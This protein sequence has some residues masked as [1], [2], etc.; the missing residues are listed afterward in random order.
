[1]VKKK[2]KKI[3]GVRLKNLDERI[4]VNILDKKKYR[5]I[6]FNNN[7]EQ[8][9]TLPIKRD[10]KTFTWNKKTYIT[11]FENNTYFKRNNFFKTFKYFFYN[12]N[13]PKP[14]NLN[15]LGNPKFDT[16]L[17]NTL[18]ET[19]VVNDL[20]SANRKGLSEL[21]TPKNVIIG[22]ILLVI[23]YYFLNGGTIV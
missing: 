17:F 9:A 5:A 15:G 12:I 18:L 19:K 16:E 21:L 3:L 1:M 6:I 2:R 11:D 20:N 8:I 22:I 10:A 7:G 13:E 14:I 4:L 23:G